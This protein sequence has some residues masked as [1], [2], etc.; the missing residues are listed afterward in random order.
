MATQEAQPTETHTSS[1]A[2]WLSET[3]FCDCEE[4]CVHAE[5]QRLAA[6]QHEALVPLMLAQSRMLDG[7]AE[8]SKERQEELWR[9]LHAC[10]DAARKALKAAEALKER[11]E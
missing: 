10:E 6:Q 1:L 3:T 8:S 2:K 9:N 4:W 11:Y 7:W 5:V